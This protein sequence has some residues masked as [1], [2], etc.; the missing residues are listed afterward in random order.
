MKGVDDWLKQQSGDKKQA[1][2]D[3]LDRID[4]THKDLTRATKRWQKW[5]KKQESQTKGT[6]VTI[7]FSQIKLESVQWVSDGR[8]PTKMLTGVIGDPEQGKSTYL[9]W[10]AA[11]ASRGQLAGE[12]A[13]KPVGVC[14]CS[15]ED[16][17]ASVIGPRL[18][19]AGA[20]M[21]RVHLME[22]HDE[23]HL[24]RGVLFPDDAAA[25]RT[26]MQETGSKILIV[27]P[28]VAH[29]PSGLNSW[30]DQDIRRA[31]SAMSR[32]A[33]E[34]E[35]AVIF[36]C[37][38]NKNASAPN[39]L[40]RIGS[41]IGIP[42]AARSILW[43]AP[44]PLDPTNEY[45][46][47]L[48]HLKC[49]V[50]KKAPTLRYRTESHVLAGNIP[51]SKI[52]W[53]GE[54]SAIKADDLMQPPHE[55]QEHLSALDEAKQWLQGIV[56]KEGKEAALILAE[57]KKAGFSEKTLR[58]AKSSLGIEAQ[59]DGISKLWSWVLPS[60]AKGQGGQGS[61][62]EP[63]GHLTPSHKKTINII[64][65]IETGGQVAKMAVVENDGH[66]A[67]HLEGTA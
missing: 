59:F 44:D 9:A 63:S 5:K 58:R 54:A 47:V 66:L 64:N 60:K 17:P 30:R 1:F 26:R 8:I 37:H 34:L 2:L 12:Y 42:A 48:L 61:V 4:L 7:P 29:L 38:L 14:V 20:D 55:N 6:V 53:V 22:F 11:Q 57:A 43:A 50:A 25:I 52:L 15:A 10:V 27:D 51:T 41:S 40:Y 32:L 16:S 65:N 45:A 3:Y 19:I 21:D 62:S 49:N 46:H 13:G 36:L 31:L 23:H 35:A 67:D 33:D 24:A 28:L 56:G 39:P 18:T